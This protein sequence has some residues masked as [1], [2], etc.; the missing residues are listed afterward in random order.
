MLDTPPC[1]LGG[2]PQWWPHTVTDHARER[3]TGAAVA[4][5]TFRPVAPLLCVWGADTA[6]EWD[7]ISKMSDRQDT[8]RR[9]NARKAAA[10]RLQQSYPWLRYT[11]AYAASPPQANRWREFADTDGVVATTVCAS[12]IAEA[13]ALLVGAADKCRDTPERDRRL[14]GVVFAQWLSL[15]LSEAVVYTETVRATAPLFPDYPFQ[16]SPAP[17]FP[18][19][20]RTRI[21]LHE[22]TTVL[23]D[24]SW[25]AS[26]QIAPEVPTEV[27]EAAR[28]I[29]AL[30][31]WVSTPP[32]VHGAA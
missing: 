13:G 2:P 8:P 15:C 28:H 27:R 4:N 14:Q 3:P 5:L 19:P 1:P 20:L 12:L 6:T 9:H 11:E 31:A 18:G 16:L 30:R 25:T 10:R 32:A 24:A 21:G 22:V 7:G 23:T 29:E 17:P 26:A